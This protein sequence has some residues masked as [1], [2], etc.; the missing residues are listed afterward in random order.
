[1]KNWSTDIAE[2]QK[3]P[4][5]FSIWR[6]EHLINFGLDDE[7]IDLNELKTYWNNL[8]IDPYKRKFLSLFI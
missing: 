5:K 2:L 7:K 8:N 1:M 4:E 6:L 3:D